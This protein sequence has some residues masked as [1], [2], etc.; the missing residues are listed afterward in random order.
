MRR[1]PPDPFAIINSRTRTPTPSRVTTAASGASSD[2]A[3]VAQMDLGSEE[4]PQLGRFAIEAVRPQPKDQLLGGVIHDPELL[5]HGASW[6]VSELP[7]LR[8]PEPPSGNPR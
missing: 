2:P 3:H 6:L 1:S 5:G 4:G 8:Y 7:L